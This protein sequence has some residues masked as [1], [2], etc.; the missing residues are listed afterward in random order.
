MIII[1]T[2]GACKGNPGN[3]GYAFKIMHPDGTITSRSYGVL[4]TTNNRMELNAVIT[5]LKSLLDIGYPA[6]TKCTVYTDSAYVSS[7]FNKGWLSRWIS[8]NYKGIKNI[9]LWKNIAELN[10]YFELL[11]IPVKGHSG[12][13][14]NDEVDKMASDACNN[15]GLI[16]SHEIKIDKE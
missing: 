4:D 3:G 15:R 8:T 13:I 16:E 2:D 1:Y 14:H 9:D 6:G 5:A 12:D 10:E 7:P 11:F